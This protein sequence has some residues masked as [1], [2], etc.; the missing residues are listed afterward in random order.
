MK[1][2]VC[3]SEIK[4]KYCPKCGQYHKNER[5][6][7]KMM[8]GDLFGNL[9]SLEKSILK[10]I[11]IGLVQPKMLITNYWNGYRGYYYSPSKFLTI[12][13]LFFLLQI[14]LKKKFLGIYVSSKFAEQFSVLLF[15]IFLYSIITYIVY[16]KFKKNYYEHLILNIYNVSLWSIIFIPISLL[17][18]ISGLEIIST[19]ILFIY[20]ILI[21]VWNSKVFE[22]SNKKRFIYITLHII[23]LI[24]AFF[25]IYKIFGD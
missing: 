1:C 8:F 23:L 2:S 15:L 20:L 4:E 24:I 12:A 17:I 11:K 22:L 18:S 19:N 3:S 5:I 13:S 16:Y 6:S 9:F 10:N 14:S 21:I 25:I 7:I